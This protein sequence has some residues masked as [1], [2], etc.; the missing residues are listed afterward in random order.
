MIV[1]LIFGLFDLILHNHLHIFESFTQKLDF[2]DKDCEFL[3]DCDLPFLK[4]FTPF[5]C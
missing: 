3:N 4:K 2:F 5:S 1:I